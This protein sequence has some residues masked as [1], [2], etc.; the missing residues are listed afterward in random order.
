MFFRLALSCNKIYLQLLCV[1]TLASCG[2]VN[3]A[4]IPI[5]GTI[6]AFGDSLTVG[7]GAE[8]SKSYPAVLAQ[9]SGRHVI[10]AGAS[11]ETTAQGLERLSGILDQSTP[12]LL[13][14]LEGGN[15]I[16]RNQDLA[17]TKQNLAEMI[18]LAQSYGAVVVLIGVPEKRL[19]S[20]AAPLYEEL[21]KEYGLVF[22]GE[23]IA[24]L[25]REPQYKSDMVHFN[26]QGYRQLA[27]SIYQS[28]VE[29]GA[30]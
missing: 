4:P 6:L 25:L 2:P 17:R 7:V 10:N 20:D 26:A 22:E 21:A 29:R 3:L 11:G 23:L 1:V 28:L 15:D 12:D 14:L 30:L 5:D 13:I 16:L 8:K 19:F 9:L 27:E 18:E 24:S